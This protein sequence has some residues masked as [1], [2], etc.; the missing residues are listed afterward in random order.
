MAKARTPRPASGPGSP[1]LATLEWFVISAGGQVTLGA[2]PPIGCAVI[3][4]DGQHTRV[5]LQRQTDENLMRL[6]LRFDEA[7]VRTLDHNAVID[8]INPRR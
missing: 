8:E 2:V 5:A 1:L 3:A 7:L 4:H 6:L